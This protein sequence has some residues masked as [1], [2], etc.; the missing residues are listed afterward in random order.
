MDVN[1]FRSKELW[2]PVGLRAVFGGQIIG[3]ALKAATRTIDSKFHVH[4]LHCYF[5]LPGDHKIPIIF[6]VA[7]DRTGR[8]Y[9]TRSVTATQK[10]KTIFSMMASFTIPETSL[11]EFQIRMPNVPSPDDFKSTEEQMRELLDNPKAKFFHNSI[12]MRLQQV[13][14]LNPAYSD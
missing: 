6:R 4:S 11:L 2:I 5:L 13:P 10:G 3:L 8:S 7:E 1:L 9:A 12:R 14:F